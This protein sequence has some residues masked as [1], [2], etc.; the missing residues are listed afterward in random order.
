MRNVFVALTAALGLALLAAC[1]DSVSA[2][3]HADDAAPS[4]SIAAPAAGAVVSGTVILRA[5]ADDN[6][7]VAG[8]RFLSGNQ[9]IGQEATQPPFEIEWDTRDWANG[10]RSLV[11]EARDAQGNKARSS[12]VPVDILN[13]G[14]LRVEA[15]VTGGG[16]NTGSAVIL[17]DGAQ[18]G[19]L[20]AGALDV[21]GLPVGSHVVGLHGLSFNCT[22]A[23]Q[24][25][26]IRADAVTLVAFPLTCLKTGTARITVVNE[27]PGTDPDVISIMADGVQ[28][29]TV[30][31]AGGAL[32][33]PLTIGSHSIELGLLAFYCSATGRWLEVLAGETTSIQVPVDCFDPPEQTIVFSRAEEGLWHPDLFRLELD[34]TGLVRL[35]DTPQQAE[36]E[37]SWSP[38]GAHIAF[39]TWDGESWG[40]IAVMNAN[41]SGVTQLTSDGR[42]N[43][44][45][46]WSPD[47]GRIVY[48][49]DL[50]PTD[51]WAEH[52]RHRLVVMDA[53]GGARIQI[54]F[55]ADWY[56]D[57]PGGWSSDG[58]RILFQ[59][60]YLDG[61]D[62]SE[63]YLVNPDGSDLTLIS[64]EGS[65][66]FAP[67]WSPDGTRIAF[68]LYRGDPCCGSDIAIVNADGSGLVEIT[69]TAEFEW[70][71]AWTRDGAWIV[72]TRDGRM[73]ITRADG[74][75]SFVL[76]PDSERTWNLALS[77]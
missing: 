18:R 64:Q 54:T 50:V 31:G 9:V 40:E 41:G 1:A 10:R 46:K 12:E 49:S 19:S 32:E 27:G 76:L 47:G 11:A 51:F 39:T 25:V 68:G 45:P 34:G 77:P 23:D 43:M 75:E 6:V 15:Y 42:W 28:R 26:E 30:S 67:A 21:K 17:I 2:P 8:V 7:G 35:T 65:A 53:D 62:R 66:G 29:G 14:T 55:G 13:T 56:Q 16:E 61:S 71:P 74:S 52:G 36:V 5:T 4:V 22:A 48:T 63:F 24:Q 73:A 44:L 20:A 59:R 3:D 60:Y 37:P 57:L 33:L 72:F 38:D 58:Q 70:E 69:H